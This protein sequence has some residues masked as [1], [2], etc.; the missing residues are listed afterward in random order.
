MALFLICTP[1]L[2]L[3]NR[4]LSSFL[5]SLTRWVQLWNGRP[6]ILSLAKWRT[7]GESWYGCNDYN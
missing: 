4:P 2:T 7:A 5:E 1:P 6:S 3:M